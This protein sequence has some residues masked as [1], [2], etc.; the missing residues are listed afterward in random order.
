MEAGEHGVGG[1]DGVVVHLWRSDGV[2]NSSSQAGLVCP[3]S[4][5]IVV[6]TAA[7]PRVVARLLNSPLFAL[8]GY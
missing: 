3:S 5:T 6:H 7:L 2:E 1:D 8:Q 4:G